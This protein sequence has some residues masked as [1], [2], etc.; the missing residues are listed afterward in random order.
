MVEVAVSL[1]EPVEL[2]V[3]SRQPARRVECLS[4]QLADE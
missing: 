1:V 4:I 2:H 3:A